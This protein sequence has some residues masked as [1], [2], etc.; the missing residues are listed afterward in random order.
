VLLVQAAF[1]LFF[2]W[3]ILKFTKL[4]PKLSF[5]SPILLCYAFGIVIANLAFIPVD[6][7]LSMS[8]AEVAVPIA[9]P[10]VL[11]S[12]DIMKC[13]R[14]AKKTIL[15]FG[16]VII[17][18]MVSSALGAFIFASRV[19][20]FWQ[21]A[22]MLV[23]VYTGGTPNLMAVG[24]G[25]GVKE[26]TIILVNTADV[27]MGG[28][29]LLFLM[30]LA[31]PLLSKFLPPFKYQE[32]AA[33]AEGGAEVV[34]ESLQL[35]KKKEKFKKIALALGL[36]LA[37]VGVSAL[38]SLLIAGEM[39]IGLVILTITTLGITGSL[40]KKIRTIEGTYEVGQYLLLVFSIAIGTTVNFKEML[41]SS[42][43]IFLYTGFVMTVAILLHF[44]L[45]ALFR[46]D[47]DTT[48]ITST[49]GIFGPP[50]IPPVAGILK[51]KEV[52]VTGLTISLVGYALGNY[53]GMLLAYFLMP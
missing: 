41:S 4:S 6:S 50:F 37:I 31:K 46:I 2:P 45:A 17:S 14:L 21:V 39:A 8:V 36:S 43:T 30:V 25:L 5:F 42:P 10:L 26:E 48:I 23:G 38:V 22:G 1:I 52:I 27:F 12:T 3:V 15:S 19:E 28:L 13:L 40:F 18:G 24:M 34:L 53:L 32:E 29:Y 11:F 9:I 33:S 20:E 7:S 16:L 51:N 47:V 44:S 35:L 49:A